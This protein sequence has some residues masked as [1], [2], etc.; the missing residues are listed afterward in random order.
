MD[1]RIDNPDNNLEFGR[2]YVKM[3]LTINGKEG[4]PFDAYKVCPQSRIADYCVRSSLVVSDAD[5]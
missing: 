4:K 3:N 2:I 1:I 5:R